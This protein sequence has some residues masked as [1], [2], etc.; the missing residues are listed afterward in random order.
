MTRLSPCLCIHCNTYPRRTDSHFSIH[1]GAPTNLWHTQHYVL[2]IKL[3]RTHNALCLIVPRPSI[4]TWCFHVRMTRLSPCLCIHCNTY[5]RRTDSHFSIHAG[6][7]TNL[8]HTYYVLPITLIRTHNT[9][10]LIVPRPSIHTWCFHVRMTR[11]SPCLC[12]HC[13][14]YPQRTD[15]HFSIHAGALTNLWHI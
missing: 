12:I 15:S 4:H 5:P 7:F 3:T 11:L 1:A 14:T 9:L 10:C 8:W 13:N 6:A 2:P